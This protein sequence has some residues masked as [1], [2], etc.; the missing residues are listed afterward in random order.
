MPGTPVEVNVP[1]E[2]GVYLPQ[3]ALQQVEGRWGVFIVEQ[4]QAVFIPVKRGMEVKDEVLVQE[5]LKPGDT[6]V[7]EGAYL[8]KAYQQKRSEP[9]GE[10]GH[11]H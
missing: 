10:G 1:L 4:E 6:V 8:L 11:G 3:A 7:A 5:G 9:E 2:M